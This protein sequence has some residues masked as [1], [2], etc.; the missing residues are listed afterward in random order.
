MSHSKVIAII[1]PV[2]SIPLLLAVISKIGNFYYEK[3][4]A[5]NE[6]NKF[7]SNDSNDFFNFYSDGYYSNR[8]F[9]DSSYEKYNSYFYNN[10][11]R[12]SYNDNYSSQFSSSSYYTASDIQKMLENNK[13]PKEILEFCLNGKYNRSNDETKILQDCLKTAVKKAK[14]RYN[15]NDE[16]QNLAAHISNLKK[17][18]VV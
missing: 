6:S 15:E 8:D 13:S 11:S 18:K 4:K 12:N 17:G 14:D 10:N 1:L 16:W 3:F 2:L 9:N 7:S 5:D